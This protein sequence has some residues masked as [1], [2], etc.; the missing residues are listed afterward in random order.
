MNERYEVKNK[1]Q[2]ERIS[3]TFQRNYQLKE[4][5]SHKSDRFYG[6]NELQLVF[7]ILKVYIFWFN[8]LHIWYLVNIFFLPYIYELLIPWLFSLR[9]T[10]DFDL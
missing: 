1:S 9:S 3:I 5:S 6:F 4:N 2:D 8:L 7:D 10:I